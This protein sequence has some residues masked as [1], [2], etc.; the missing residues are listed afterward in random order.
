MIE[1]LA[2]QSR[3]Q[4]ATTLAEQVL[5]ENPQ[6]DTAKA[7][8]ASL[9]LRGGD[10]KDLDTA[11]TEFQTVLARMPDNPVVRFNYG[12]AL[13]AKGQLGPAKVQLQEAIKLRSTYLPPKMALA[14]IH[15]R[16]REFPRVI[17]L[18]EEILKQ[19]PG[20]VTARILRASGMI[21][22][23]DTAGAR[24]DLEDIVHRSPDIREARFLL[25]LLDFQDKRWNEAEAGFKSLWEGNPPELRGLFGLV[26]TM[27]V[28]NRAP[29]A[30]ALL[31]KSLQGNQAHSAAIRMAIANVATRSNDHATALRIYEQLVKEL[32]K[33][34]V[35]WLRLGRSY[36][37]ANRL[38]DSLRA[39]EA[40]RD[41]DRRQVAPWLEIAVIMELQQR[42][43]AIRPVYEEIL[44]LSPDN[45]IALNNLAYI[46]ADNAVELDQALS[47][48]QRAR[49]KLPNHPDIADTLGWVYIKKNLSDDAIK[50]FRDLLNKRPEHVTWRYHLA[51]ALFQKGDKL[52][53][54]RELEAALRNKPTKD[55]DS[56]IRE[57]L[58]RI[59]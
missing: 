37:Q 44:K 45:P 25:A 11:L 10:R 24:Q 27:V 5:K 39:F 16:E 49:Q 33:S 1:I 20:L 23:R 29:A 40:A 43:S 48:A 13:M 19:S 21:G 41:I 59:G 55:E 38:D 31:E 46:L 47:Y 30:K 34:Q 17:A 9:R 58:S 26:E 28:T 15:L 42:K 22:N 36:R 50:I 3:N 35:M 53:A 52:Q 56:K 57:L 12:E 54:R 51:I 4:E 18:A 14:Y 32:P 8:R 7:L 6:D 2:F